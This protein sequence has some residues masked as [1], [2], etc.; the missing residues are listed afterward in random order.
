MSEELD[1]QDLI[2]YMNETPNEFIIIV[3]GLDTG[4]GED[5]REEYI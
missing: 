1:I 2:Q 4:G 3:E 5:V